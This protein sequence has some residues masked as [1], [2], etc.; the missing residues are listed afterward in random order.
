M[1]AKGE[2]TGLSQNK[3]ALR[4]QLGFAKNWI[5]IDLRNH[6]NAV[7]HLSSVCGLNVFL[8]FSPS[9]PPSPVSLG[10]S[11]WWEMLWLMALSFTHF[12]INYFPLG[13]K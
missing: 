8:S 4:M 10:L 11:T 5:E 1:G 2:Y 7:Y 9:V 13:P 12:S 6:Q 3:Q